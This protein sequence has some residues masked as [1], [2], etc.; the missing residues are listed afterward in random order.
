[1]LG[2]EAA[3]NAWRRANEAAHATLL[4]IVEGDE[5]D[6]SLTLD[7]ESLLR[8]WPR[9]PACRPTRSTGCHPR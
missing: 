8:E 4:A 6:R 3:L 9:A 2:T 5:T 7:L 1:V